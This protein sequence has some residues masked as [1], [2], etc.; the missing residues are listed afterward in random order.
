MLVRLNKEWFNFSQ[1]KAN[2]ED[3]RFATSTG[4][5][6]AYEIDEWDAAA[7]TASVWVRIPTIKGNAR[8]EIKMY[9]GKADA[10][11][12]SSGAAVFN[13]SNGYLASG[14]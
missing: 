11:S 6:M 9:W 4:T 8:Q 12:E 7:G 10:T 2:G 13:E 5:P 1:A 3:I 14:T